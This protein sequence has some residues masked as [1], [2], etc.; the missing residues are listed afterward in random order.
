MRA[1]KY[2]S[3]GKLKI[4]ELSGKIL[5]T[6]EISGNPP[7]YFSQKEVSYIIILE[8]GQGAM[9]WRCCQIVVGCDLGLRFDSLSPTDS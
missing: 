6:T 2:K 4:P 3:G 8:D 7:Y 5:R 9:I 1:N